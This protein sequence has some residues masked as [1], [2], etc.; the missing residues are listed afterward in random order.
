MKLRI[1]DIGEISTAVGLAYVQYT[2]DGN[3][4]AELVRVLPGFH[5]T[6]PSD[7]VELAKQKELYFVFYTL[8]YAVRA[9]QTKIVS[10]QPVP[11]WAKAVPP[12]RHAAGRA[13]DGRTLSWRIIPALAEFTVPFLQRTPV[14]SELTRE[15]LKL[16]V[17]QL[18]PHPVM[19]RELARGW[20]PERNEELEDQDRARAQ[21][22]R[23]AGQQANS[24]P[25]DQALQ[26]YLYFP[27]KSNAEKAAQWFRSQG[28]S[29]ETRLAADNN[30]WLTLVKHASPSNQ[31][32]IDKLRAEIEALASKLD[33]E[34]DGWEL[35]V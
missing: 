29:V 13:P 27:E 21:A 8:R 33:G 10:N 18:W 15:E 2:H 22:K 3:D 11:D 9:G 17:H 25:L 14:V 6:R 16:S 1:G 5:Q 19:V 7:F 28:F 34:Y 35:A 20:T 26:H 32:E 4:M 30:S 23:N 24:V 12:M 31:E